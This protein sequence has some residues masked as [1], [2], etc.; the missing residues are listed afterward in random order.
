MN[1]TEPISLSICNRG[2]KT[3]KKRGEIETHLCGSRNLGEHVEEEMND[4]SV[5]ENRSDESTEKGDE[6][7]RPCFCASSS[8]PHLKA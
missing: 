6:G 4:A 3:T 2:D 5:Q 1:P 8:S 7:S